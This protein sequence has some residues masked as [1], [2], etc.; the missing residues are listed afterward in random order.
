M[1]AKKHISDQHTI[2]TVSTAHCAVLNDTPKT[3]QI[4]NLLERIGETEALYNQLRHEYFNLTH[5][6]VYNHAAIYKTP[7]I[8]VLNYQIQEWLSSSDSQL[9]SDLGLV[10]AKYKTKLNRL[11]TNITTM[12]RSAVELQDKLDTL[13]SCKYDKLRTIVLAPSS[14]TVDTL[15]NVKFG[16]SKIEPL[17]LTIKEDMNTFYIKFASDPYRILKRIQKQKNINL[18]IWGKREQAK[19]RSELEK[20]LRERLDVP[21]ITEE[22]VDLSPLAVIA[23]KTK[24]LVDSIYEYTGYRCSSFKLRHAMRLKFEYLNKDKEIYKCATNITKAL[25]SRITRKNKRKYREK[26]M[27][28]IEN[29]PPHRLT[30]IENECLL[31]AYSLN[32]QPFKVKD[33]EIYIYYRKNIITQM[34]KHG[35]RLIM[36]D[37]TFARCLDK[38]EQLIL[39]AYRYS[40]HNRVFAAVLC[41]SHTASAYYKILFHFKTIGVFRRLQYVVSDFERGMISAIKTLGY[42]HQPC[43]FHYAAAITRHYDTLASFF[44]QISGVED[45]ADPLFMQALKYSL[46]VPKDYKHQ[47]FYIIYILFHPLMRDSSVKL[48][49]LK[50]T[51]DFCCTGKLQNHT[52]SLVDDDMVITNN[53]LECQ[54]NQ[55][56]R[57]L[58]TSSSEYDLFE[59][60]KRVFLEVLLPSERETNFTA[61]LKQFQKAFYENRYESFIL[62]SEMGKS[63]GMF[64][65]HKNKRCKN[66]EFKLYVEQSKKLFPRKHRGLQV[67]KY[68]F[69]QLKAHW[70]NKTL[71]NVAKSSC[72]Y[73][74]VQIILNVNKP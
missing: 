19:Y 36:L 46:F 23:N 9:K 31:Q 72:F 20:S 48:H 62:E 13:D 6:R 70:E 54:N 63:P 55:L 57:F 8:N 41:N 42:I 25:S 60:M 7:E 52:F 68:F 32:V 16:L 61:Y 4:A 14:I 71:A 22:P 21:V 45:K 27:L 44:K 64:T 28:N 38:K 35:P 34:K 17:S 58:R 18:A 67:Y 2:R 30:C 40:G 1:D 59:G 29:I 51:Y 3:P 69:T 26:T 5:A 73:E 12:E 10:F 37:G 15:K 74:F 56:K 65:Y 11:N 47:Y 66:N 50:Y 53:F 33:D 43:Y 39:L 24:F 49:M